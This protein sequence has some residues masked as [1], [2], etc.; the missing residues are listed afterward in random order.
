[1]EKDLLQTSFIEKRKYK[2]IKNQFIVRFR[3]KPEDKQILSGWDMVSVDNLGAGGIL[4]YYNQKINPGSLLDIKIN[5]PTISEPVN[6][7][8]KVLRVEEPKNSRML[9]IAAAFTEIEKSSQDEINRSA[10]EFFSYKA[11]KIVY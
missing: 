3:I 1:M 6:C 9:R 5:F 10:E 11:G 4:F 2:R 7:E 8:G